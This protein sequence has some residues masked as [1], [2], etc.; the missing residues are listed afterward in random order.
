MAFALLLLPAAP[1]HAS[2]SGGSATPRR[3]QHRHG[4]DSEPSARPPHDNQT[5]AAAAAAAAPPQERSA[6]ET[7][8]TRADAWLANK[9]HG[10]IAAWDTS[11]ETDL[12]RV[13]EGADGFSEDLNAYVF[14][15]SF[16][17]WWLG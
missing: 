5:T 12:A 15:R 14:W 11:G 7:L 9:T 13:F 1:A 2:G 8:Q 10:P 3:S 4:R 16:A 6:V 17:W